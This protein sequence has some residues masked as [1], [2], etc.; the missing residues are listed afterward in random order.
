MLLHAAALTI[1]QLCI[2]LLF[3]R[4]NTLHYKMTL[5]NAWKVVTAAVPRLAGNVSGFVITAGLFSES[6]DGGDWRPGGGNTA[7]KWR[8]CNP[9]TIHNLRQWPH[10]RQS[11]HNLGKA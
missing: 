11:L 3:L 1:L 4:I 2:L 6:R 8:R 10:K 7:A 5:Y 9:G